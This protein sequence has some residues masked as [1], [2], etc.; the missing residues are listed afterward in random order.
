MYATRV[1]ESL[2]LVYGHIIYPMIFLCTEADFRNLLNCAWDAFARMSLGLWKTMGRWNS[3]SRTAFQ[4]IVGRKELMKQ[5]KKVAADIV[6]LYRDVFNTAW[7][8]ADEIKDKLKGHQSA[9]T[10][11]YKEIRQPFL[12]TLTGKGHNVEETPGVFS[13]IFG[14]LS[15]YQK[16]VQACKTSGFCYADESDGAS[17]Q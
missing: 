5:C 14:T 9:A 7:V 1:K 4:N 16:L 13:K 11:S 6:D 8:T 3:V 15:N 10:K 17:T 12:V 2:V